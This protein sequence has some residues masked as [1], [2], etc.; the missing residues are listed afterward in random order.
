MSACVQS[1]RSPES[2]GVGGPSEHSCPSKCNQ[3]EVATG[4]SWE[5]MVKLVTGHS[6]RVTASPL[7]CPMGMVNQDKGAPGDQ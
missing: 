5:F 1:P 4:W 2:G 7:S 6:D 3:D